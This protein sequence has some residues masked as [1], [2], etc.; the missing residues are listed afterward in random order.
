MVF[1][2]SE[3]FS[4]RIHI[5]EMRIAG[6]GWA[7]RRGAGGGRLGP[8]LSGGESRRFSF[9]GSALGGPCRT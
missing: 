4:R 1:Y 9:K 8:Q 6:S 5:L 2:T 7:L 3:M